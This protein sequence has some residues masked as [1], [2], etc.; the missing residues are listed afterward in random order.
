MSTVVVQKGEEE[1]QVQ[2]QAAIPNREDQTDRHKIM[3]H[4]DNRNIKTKASCNTTLLVFVKINSI[5]A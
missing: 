3:Y 2:I 5:I 1:D 4:Q